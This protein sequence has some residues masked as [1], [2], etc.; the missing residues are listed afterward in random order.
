MFKTMENSV[1]FVEETGNNCV[2]FADLFTV[3]KFY[4]GLVVVKSAGFRQVYSFVLRV[5]THK[6]FRVFKSVC[7]LVF[8][9]I[10]K[11]YNN[12]LLF[13][14]FNYCNWRIA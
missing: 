11:T 13:N 5:V 6:T 10:H 4:L 7:G 9:A 3:V 2:G 14:I 12:L 8:H 1:I